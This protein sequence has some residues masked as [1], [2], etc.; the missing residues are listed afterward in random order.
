ML[1]RRRIDTPAPIRSSLADAAF[2]V[3]ERVVWGGADALRRL[4]EMVKWP[5]ERLV[6]AIERGLVWPLEERAGG[7]SASL[8]IGGVAVLGLLAATAAG[9]GLVLASGGGGSGGGVRNVSAPV[10]PPVLA[11]A[12]DVAPT[13]SAPALQ[14]AKPDFAAGDDGVVAKGSAEASPSAGSTAS[15]GST[16]EVARSASGAGGSGAKIESPGPTAI[17]VAR[18][19]AGAFVLY[20]IGGEDADVRGVFDETA[21]A[22][23]TRSLLQREPRQPAGAAVP[24]AKVLNVV[25]GPHLGDTYTLSV[26]L[27]RVG[28]TSELRLDMQRDRKTGEWRVTDVLG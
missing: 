11:P 21:T 14:G 4:V 26:S 3:E 24:K 20:E 13:A 6:W 23:V 22:Q 1:G 19:F 16:S 28:I 2:A 8:R 12:Q 7:R 17:K 5:F 9:V 25:P 10:P 27:L 15:A 18:Q